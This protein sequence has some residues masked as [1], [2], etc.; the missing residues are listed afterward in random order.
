[1]LAGNP[2]NSWFSA[3]SQISPTLVSSLYD[4]SNSQSMECTILCFTGISQFSPQGPGALWIIHAWVCVIAGGLGPWC[5]F[6]ETFT[7]LESGQKKAVCS[8]NCIF[9]IRKG[10]DQK[11]V[12]PMVRHKKCQ[13]EGE[14]FFYVKPFMYTKTTLANILLGQILVMVC[15]Y[16][17]R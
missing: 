7:K 11:M 5:G 9:S 17:P 12:F 10:R 16:L 15:K 3:G 13:V 4:L 2:V 6:C 1:M 8:P 14:T